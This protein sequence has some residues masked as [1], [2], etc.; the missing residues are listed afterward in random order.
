M[1]EYQSW[2]K[3]ENVCSGGLDLTVCDC[4]ATIQQQNTRKSKI[5]V[6]FIHR[7]I[8]KFSSLLRISKSLSFITCS[9]YRQILWMY[10]HILWLFLFQGNWAVIGNRMG[11]LLWHHRLFKEKQTLVHVIQYNTVR[12]HKFSFVDQQIWKQR[13][14]KEQSL[15]LIQRLMFQVIVFSYWITRY[16]VLRALRCHYSRHVQFVALS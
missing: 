1:T 15:Q 8:Y 14:N 7:N 2:Y 4:C 9:R 11:Y 10:V 12:Y 5:I 6:K 16:I 3:I 13:C